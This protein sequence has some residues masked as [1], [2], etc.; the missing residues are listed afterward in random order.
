MK[1]KIAIIIERAEIILGGAER[2]VFELAG[3]LT[4][5]GLETHIIAAKGQTNTLGCY[6]QR[7]QILSIC[8][9]KMRDCGLWN[10]ARGCN[11]RLLVWYKL[12]LE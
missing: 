7:V 6:S 4:A 11:R 10:L 9:I 3:A 12:C 1:K 2:S 5:C 8:E